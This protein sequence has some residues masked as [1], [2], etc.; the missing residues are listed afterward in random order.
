MK[1]VEV[2]D[3]KD[4]KNNKI[5]RKDYGFIQELSQI[6]QKISKENKHIVIAG[7]FNYDLL[8]HNDNKDVK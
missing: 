6:L 2:L 3:E 5:I 1:W 8:K 7:D 4:K